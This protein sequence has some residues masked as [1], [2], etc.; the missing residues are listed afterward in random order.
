[1]VKC[2]EIIKYWLCCYKGGEDDYDIDTICNI[3]WSAYQFDDTLYGAIKTNKENN[4][5]N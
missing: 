2:C 1:M 5:T 3:D 4:D